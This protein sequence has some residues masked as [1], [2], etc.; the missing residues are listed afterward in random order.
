MSEESGHDSDIQI[1]G[2]SNGSGF[3]Q[4]VAVGVLV[5]LILIFAQVILAKVGANKVQRFITEKEE[6]VKSKLTNSF[7]D[8]LQTH[9]KTKRVANS[10]SVKED[11]S[12]PI[13]AVKKQDSDGIEE[14]N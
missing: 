13:P 4:T 14:V 7:Y 8:A 6:L 1:E 3:F 12:S 2:F 9:H 11:G 10:S 5:N